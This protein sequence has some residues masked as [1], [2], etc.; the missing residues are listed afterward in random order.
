[1]TCAAVISVDTTTACEEPLA[2]AG[3]FFWRLWHKKIGLW[4]AQRLAGL[5]CF[6]T[7]SG[8]KRD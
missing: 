7:W 1:M 4:Y 3:G 2:S 6:R 8:D 5:M